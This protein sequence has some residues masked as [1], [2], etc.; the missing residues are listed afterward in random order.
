MGGVLSV[1]NYF[2]IRT[3]RH[4]FGYPR[5]SFAFSAKSIEQLFLEYNGLNAVSAKYF[6]LQILSEIKSAV[7]S[8]DVDMYKT[9][10]SLLDYVIASKS[11]E[12]MQK[13]ELTALEVVG[14]INLITLACK[15]AA[16]KVL[17]YLLSDQNVNFIL[18]FRI[19]RND[20]SPEEED[21]ESHNAIYYAIRSNVTSILEILIDKW[22]N[23]YFKDTQKLDDVLSKA[24]NELLVRNIP[25]KKD[26]ELFLKK[27]LVD[28]RFFDNSSS[29][30]KPPN[31]PKDLLMLRIEYVLEKIA[32]I[33]TN[34]FDDKNELD[35][36]F[37]L[38]TKFV[39]QNIHTIKSQLSFTYDRLPWEEMEFCLIIFIR[40]CVK[41]FRL[42]PLYCFVLNKERLLSH[43]ENFSIRLKH[44]KE[45]LKTIDISKVPNKRITRKEIIEKE[46]NKVFGDLYND[47]KAIRDVYTLEKMK[48]YTDI[49]L[50]ADPR[51][52]EGHILITR[53]L[54]VT[55][56]HFNNSPS[57]PKL[58]DTAANFLLSVL[59]RN[60]ADII[61][62]L[63]NSLSHLEAFCL[64]GEIE[65]NA[66]SFFANIQ[67][68]I[69]KISSAISDILYRAKITVIISL[70]QEMTRHESTVGKKIFVEQNHASAASLTK[71]LEETKHLNLGEIGLLEKLVL[72]LEVELD[73]EINYSKE[74]FH[75]LHA[76]IEGRSPTIPQQSPDLTTKLRDSLLSSDMKD[77]LKY[78][79]HV[80]SNVDSTSLLTENEYFVTDGKIDIDEVT[81]IMR[82]I[83]V[84]INLR[85]NKVLLNRIKSQDATTTW[86]I[87]PQCDDLLERLP[88]E[89][90]MDDYCTPEQIN[91]LKKLVS[92][93]EAL[94]ESKSQSDKERFHRILNKIADKK[95]ELKSIHEEIS[96][97]L[98]CNFDMV[99]TEDKYYSSTTMMRGIY[100][101]QKKLESIMQQ[102]DLKSFSDELYLISQSISSR[103]LLQYGERSKALEKAL[104]EIFDFI[105][106]RMGN[107]KWIKEFRH[108][109]HSHKKVKPYTF[110]KSIYTLKPDFAQQLPLKISLLRNVLK[111]HNL[112]SLSDEKL[113]A[114][115]NN[116]ELQILV[117]MLI[118]DIL[119]VI[120]GLPNQ[121]THI[122]YYLDSY[123]PMAYGRNLRNHIAHGNALVEM[124][125]EENFS[126]ILLNAHKIIE[127]NDILQDKL[128]KKVKNNPVKSKKSYD[129]DSSIMRK[130]KQFFIFLTEGINE[131]RVKDFIC[132]GVDIYGRDLNS[133]TALHFATKASNLEV[134]KF[135]LT[136]GLDIN[137]KD[138]SHQTVLHVA[139][140][141]GRE[142]IV[143][144]LIEEMKMQVDDKDINGKTPLHLAS[145]EGHEGVVRL[146]LRHKANTFFKDVFGY[147]PLHYAVLENHFNIVSL[148]LENETHVD[149]N[150]TFYG[151]TAL[152]LAAAKGHLNLINT[153]IE[154]EANVNFKSDMDFVPLHYA[155]SGGHFE[156]VK[157]LLLKGAETSA[158]T[159]LGLTPLHSAMDSGDVATITVLLQHGAEVKASYL[160][161]FTPLHF[162]VGYGRS[163]ASKLLMEDGADVAFPSG[164]GTTPLDI[165][166]HL[167]HFE[168]VAEFLNSSDTNSKIQAFQNAAS[169]GNLAVVKLLFTSGVAVNLLLESIAL[170]IAA[171]EG[172]TDTVKFL[173]DEGADINAQDCNGDTA[174][175][176]SSLNVRKEVVQLLIERKADILIKNNSGTFPLERIVLNGMTDLLIKEEVVIDF[177]YANDTSPFHYGAFYGDINF[178][179]Y[180]IQK[181]CPIDIRTNSG[182]TA[183]LLA[184][185]GGRVEIVNFLLD[186]GS[187]IDAEDQKGCNAL[188]H[189]VN[190]NNKKI[191]ELLI[192]KGA[193]LSAAKE[194]TLFLSAVT[195]G[196]ED[197]VDFFLS[198]NPN[199]GT[200]N[201]EI[202]EF[203]LHTAVYFGHVTI[204]KKMLE[205][206]KKDEINVKDKS[207]KTPLII[208]AERDHCEIAQILLSNG[209]DPSISSKY[210]DL[211]LLIAV[212]KGSSK[213]VE[214]L[215]NSGAGN[216]SNGK[217]STELA[218]AS[219][220]SKIVEI[221]LQN[222]NINNINWHKE[223]NLLHM[224]ASSGALEIV[225]SLIHN[226]AD[227]NRRDSSGAKPIHIAVKEGFMDVVEYFLNL[228]IAVDERGEND[229]TL[230]HYAAAG[231]HSDICKFLS[232][233]DAD[234]NAVDADGATP[235][236]IAAETGSLEALL[237]LLKIGT[238][239]D[240]RNKNNKSPLQVTKWWNIRLRISLMFASNMFSA[241]QNDNHFKLEG[242]LSTGLE[243]LKFNFVNV[244]NA[245]NITPIH[246]AAWKGYE[247]I[248]NIL[249]RYGANP[250]LRTKNDWTS[251]HYAAKFSHFEIV[252]DLLCNGAVFEAMSDS[253]KT[254]LHYSTDKNVIAI[255]EFLK[256][257]F[258]KTENKDRSCLEDLKSIEDTDVAKAVLR[259]RNLQLRTLTSVAIVN[260]HPDIDEMK[261]IF[262]TDVHVPLKMAEMSY[263]KGN[264]EESFN[265]YEVVL[266]KRI[267]I[268]HQDDSAVLEIQKKIS[269]LLLQLGD[270]KRALSLAQKVYETLQNIFG[271][272]NRETL[273]VKCLIALTLERT[274]QKQ[275]A[276]KIYQE[277]SEKQ[278]EVLGLKHK[279]T[280]ETLTNMAELLYKENKFEMALKVNREIFKA[281]TEYYEDSLWTLKIH[282]NIAKILR[283]QEKF[284]EA[285][286]LFR[287]IYEAKAKIFGSNDQETLETSTEIAE[288][289]FCMGQEEE[290]LKVHRKNMELQ[291]NLSGPNHRNKLRSRNCI[292]DIL[293]SQRKF[294]EAL[295][296]YTEDLNA[297]TLILGA[298]HA[299]IEKTQ[300]RIDFMNSHIK[301]PVL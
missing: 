100:K 144:Y 98:K 256:N 82:H 295:D 96:E 272:R 240:A 200:S 195:Q 192:K 208:A 253:G 280:L 229:W 119:S 137:A 245:K 300:K 17:G 188:K 59:P 222:S 199:I 86:K 128:G 143:E 113:Q 223:G 29:Q 277:V 160:D 37:L 123:Y 102:M 72:N 43:L 69:A 147:A 166:A 83:F 191:L 228:G 276:L 56:E 299:S 71:V 53:A 212:E 158:Q 5:K 78:L 194:R 206:V 196:H 114:C 178:V 219:K 184:T 248:A 153:L 130:Q 115:E 12:V 218:T 66:N 26:M 8:D 258:C 250:N 85:E 189:A 45:E 261:E 162:A 65:E 46:E 230:L 92:N 58:S 294:R 225:E 94:V 15:S 110:A 175:H 173:L 269:L 52:K 127:V 170:H 167:G 281:L 75:R 264:Y 50:S 161:G 156:V 263:R 40:F 177:S 76:V 32:F 47:F 215:L 278:R 89:M 28:I 150:Q 266:E 236:H 142:R 117:E 145:R 237:T 260:D 124:L 120:E 251:L 174:L 97:T 241:V 154:K 91:M 105:I 11:S 106:F 151:F 289:L 232:E 282:S 271:D 31:N 164:D 57:S 112:E 116:V 77:I 18:P 140:N 190:S 111:D 252:K 165:A 30:K 33:V 44:V 60:L 55:G 63:R 180:C 301:N 99:H 149:A 268:F 201:S 80:L 104:L 291:L 139:A 214:I 247:R 286:E 238:F 202:S 16:G 259:A 227:I 73:K 107:V 285:L 198:R 2:S 14:K 197:I 267:N 262:Q 133:R 273:A 3:H 172:H 136:F 239:Y 297:R 171:E 186:N 121:L 242:I 118:L 101:F 54:Q 39:A 159:V 235:L 7:I 62:S 125:L 181:G 19:D 287:N 134:M 187:D 243:V 135:L 217:T 179:N 279:D 255:L 36:Q 270:Y 205:K 155:A 90:E 9:L 64:R 132:K 204:V 226:N 4:L 35:E 233:R 42:E 148:L 274:G 67:T 95:M 6:Y 141:L 1:V 257:I 288:T 211:P 74:M 193:N 109:I 38:A 25:L 183:L 296:I 129:M 207:S 249:L 41:P 48:K 163:A 22:P 254:P 51:N 88:D 234:V 176:L 216:D 84:K 209:A 182:S 21:D 87:F 284:V 93:V 203:P 283:K 108:M 126:S 70:L 213:M 79:E 246:Y 152:H 224:A 168:L 27:K 10:S 23:S 185:L 20:L 49:A 146:L 265:L 13:Y 220:H 81:E 244:K 221:G 292:A 24:F 293:Y 61:T 275:Q 131:K 210:G 138:D 34:Y 231:N 157:L 169:K 298:N 290:S 103:M 68:D 122:N